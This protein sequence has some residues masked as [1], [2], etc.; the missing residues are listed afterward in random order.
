MHDSGGMRRNAPHL[1]RRRKQLAR[2]LRAQ[3]EKLQISIEAICRRVGISRWTYTKWEDG[4]R[5][6]P[7]E[8][9]PAL[10][11]VL[12]VEVAE[13]VDHVARDPRRTSSL[14]QAVAA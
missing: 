12:E 11:I 1:R 10:A 7:A 2:F 4:S 6:I 9:L 13:V 14:P 8:L 3:R 5:S